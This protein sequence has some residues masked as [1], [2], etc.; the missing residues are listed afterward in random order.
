MADIPG[1]K[2]LRLLIQQPVAMGPIRLDLG[3]AKRYVLE[4]TFD[5]GKVTNVPIS[6]GAHDDILKNLSLQTGVAI[7]ERIATQERV[8]GEKP[9][10]PGR[11]KVLPLDATQH[12]VVKA[13][14]EVTGVHPPNLDELEPWKKPID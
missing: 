10:D 7:E 4:L 14:Y 3:M 1:L 5:D 6:K 12:D 8:T 9:A 2:N 13:L 11:E